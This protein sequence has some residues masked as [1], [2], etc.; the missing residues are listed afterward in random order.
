MLVEILIVVA[1]TSLV[2][3]GVGIAAV[4]AFFKAK[5]KTA[6]TSARTIRAAAKTWWTDHDPALCPSVGDLVKDG[7]VDEDAS[8]D[9][10]WGTPFRVEC[11]GDRVSVASD[12]PDRK[13]GTPDDIRVPPMRT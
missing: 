12:G 1:I 5:V 6:T 8:P 13:K 2:A 4:E 7:V 11:D 3:A 9:D 10:P